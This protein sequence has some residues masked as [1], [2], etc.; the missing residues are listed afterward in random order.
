MSNEIA[1]IERDPTGGR[2]VAWAEAASAANA[3]AKS[4]CGTT[5]VPV[6]MK[7]P[8]DATAAIIMGDE[9]GFT[10]LAA[11]RSI[12]VVHGT[13]ALYTRSMVA[14]VLS[15]GHEIWT[16][17]STPARVEVHGKRKNSDH[18]EKSVWTTARAQTAGYLTNKKYQTN[19]EEMLYA[20]AAAEVA[21]KIGADVLLGVPYSVE[22][23][24]L[25]EAPESV[26]LVRSTTTT[27]VTR[28]RAEPVEV[29]AP[30]LDDEIIESEPV[31]EAEAATEIEPS[32]DEPP[33]DEAPA[34]IRSDLISEKQVGLLGA[35]FK[36]I[37]MNDRDEALA[38]VA[39]IIGRTIESRTELTKGEASLVIGRLQSYETQLANE[40]GT[41][42]DKTAPI[43]W[44]R[45]RSNEI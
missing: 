27:K 42:T 29:E 8:S 25:E 37:E 26:K 7:N 28:V 34:E 6:T 9:L 20:K 40:S 2:L 11:L 15:R 4:L 38:Y 36:K 12:Y 17:S 5:F 32:L 35:L 10:P 23:L 24:E 41:S 1:I 43:D 14:L 39:D 19:P 3:L 16:E 44:N 13:P 45:M 33:V 31:V 18:T 30:S 21:R 22:D